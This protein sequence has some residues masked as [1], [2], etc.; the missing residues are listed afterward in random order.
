[1]GE[2]MALSADE[3]R[4]L[5]RVAEPVKVHRELS[6]DGREALRAA[7][8]EACQA[9]ATERE[10]AAATGISKSHVHRLIV[11]ETEARQL[12]TEASSP[13]AA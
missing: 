4:R 12:I 9:G 11:A 1:M 3:T 10:I 5:A 6:A 2:A 13:P 7:V 8:Y